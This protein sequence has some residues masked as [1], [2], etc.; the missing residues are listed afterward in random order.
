MLK[1]SQKL[2]KRVN[3]LKPT[4]PTPVLH[5]LAVQLAAAGFDGGLHD[6]RVVPSKAV[7]RAKRPRSNNRVERWRSHR[8]RRQAA[9]LLVKHRVGRVFAFHGVDEFTRDLRRNNYVVAFPEQR[10]NQLHRD[11]MALGLGTVVRVDENIGVEK[12]AHALLAS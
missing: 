8:K 1:P 11:P 12:N 7:R 9:K 4:K 5:I 3:H 6:D 10:L 2:N